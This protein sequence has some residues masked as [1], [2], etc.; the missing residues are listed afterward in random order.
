M[1]R[2]RSTWRLLIASV[3]LWPA[4]AVAQ[5]LSPHDVRV[6][7]GDTIAVRGVTYRLVGFD[8]PETGDRARCPSKDAR[9]SAR[10]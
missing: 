4:L 6:L 5:Q 8:A 10:P 9:P 3:L 2:F 7:D 1:W